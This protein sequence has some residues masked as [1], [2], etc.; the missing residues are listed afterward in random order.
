MG[1]FIQTWVNV[2]IVYASIQPVTAR[3][4]V[5][6]MQTIMTV[7]HTI[8]IR[9][10]SVLKASWRIKYGDRFFNIIS[11]I[12]VDEANDYLQIVCKEAA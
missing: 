10:R 12:N 2:A 11:I 8:T 9:Y 6:G 1:G 3:E 7:S 5:W 4:Q